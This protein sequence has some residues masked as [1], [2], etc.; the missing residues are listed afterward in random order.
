MPATV[1]EPLTPK[2]SVN[3]PSANLT[4]SSVFKPKS[5]AVAAS[6]LVVRVTSPCAD[7]AIDDAET[8]P[9][10]NAAIAEFDKEP[11]ISSS[12]CIAPLTIPDILLDKCA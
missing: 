8:I 5:T 1:R 10:P 9:A 11:L 7:D 2:S 12:I 3:V 4:S 6:P